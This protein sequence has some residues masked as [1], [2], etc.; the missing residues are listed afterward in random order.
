MH[1]ACQA[2]ALF[3]QGNFIVR[4]AGFASGV[5]GTH[6]VRHNRVAVA[7]IDAGIV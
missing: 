4:C 3:L 7:G 2:E 1:Q 5:A 6:C